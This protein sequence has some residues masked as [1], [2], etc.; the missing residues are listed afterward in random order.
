MHG[1]TDRIDAPEI[2]QRFGKESQ[3]FLSDL[4]LNKIVSVQ[5]LGKDVYSRSIGKITLNDIDINAKMVECGYSWWN[6]AYA[7]KEESL[8]ILETSARASKL[9][10]WSDTETPIPPWRWRKMLKIQELQEAQKKPEKPRAIYR[11]LVTDE[12]LEI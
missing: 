2:S 6:N 8:H 1:F 7:P 9:G 5:T 12:D 3:K 4:V 11:E 10:L